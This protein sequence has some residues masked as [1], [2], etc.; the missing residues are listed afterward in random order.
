[1]SLSPPRSSSSGSEYRPNRIPVRTG[2]SLSMLKQCDAPLDDRP[3]HVAVVD[4]RRPW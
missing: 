2:I 1:M 4:G 3:R